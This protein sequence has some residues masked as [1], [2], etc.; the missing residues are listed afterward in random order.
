MILTSLEWNL[1]LF[2]SRASTK[3]FLV[4]LEARYVAL[5]TDCIEVTVRRINHPHTCMN[6][7]TM[8]PNKAMVS[9]LSQTLEV[10]TI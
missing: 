3:P 1:I 2:E 10:I 5:S 9:V 6:V 7:T 4:Y 8:T